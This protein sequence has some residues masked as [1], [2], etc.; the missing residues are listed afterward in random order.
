M[1]IA[2]ICADPGIPV[3]GNKGC[4]IHVQEILRAMR[5]RGDEVELFT[6][7]KGGSAPPDLETIHVHELPI[8]KFKETSSRENAQ[9]EWNDRVV[10]ALNLRPSWDLVYER[11]SLWSFGAL[12]WARQQRIPSI[13]EVNAPLIDEQARYRE[14]IQKHLAE[15]FTHEALDA[16]AT[17]Y[18]VSRE[19]V[20]YCRRFVRDEHPIRVIA[21]GVNTQR[22]SPELPASS[23]FDGCTIGFVG[24]LKPWHGLDCLVDAFVDVCNAADDPQAYR[25]LVVGDGP[26]RVPLQERVSAHPRVSQQVVFTGAVKADDVPAWVNSMDIAVAPYPKLENF[27]FSPL[28]LFEYMAAGR[29]II[30]SD[31]GQVADYVEHGVTG[32][33]SPAGD[34]TALADAIRRLKGN[35]NM[36]KRLGE[37]AR[38][39][40]ISRSWDHVLQQAYD[41]VPGGSNSS[42]TFENHQHVVEA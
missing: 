41:S 19:I 24:S 17:S 38:E 34:R 12:R 27:Y 20:P 23:P 35:P 4:S 18:V 9:I 32:W 11:Y 39:E 40:S 28:K 30:A 42:I 10:D 36:R 6:A 26:E 25:L 21:N 33:L 2:Y 29:A 1:R 22:F 16:A 14:L 7:R 15:S 8:E 3:F 13:L 31:A 5:K 37:R